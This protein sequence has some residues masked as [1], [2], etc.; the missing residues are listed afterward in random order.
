[1]AIKALV[2]VRLVRS[3]SFKR[4]ACDEQRVLSTKHNR[5]LV[6]Y[7]TLTAI[8]PGPMRRVI[9]STALWVSDATSWYFWGARCVTERHTAPIGSD[10][11][12]KRAA[13]HR[14]QR[15][16]LVDRDNSYCLRCRNFS[17][18]AFWARVSKKRPLLTVTHVL[19]NFGV[20]ANCPVAPPSC[21]GPGR[22]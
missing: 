10:L 2:R 12:I 11:A 14:Q 19:E 8:S 3:I 22:N 18:S 6:H 20:G 1:M 5:A 13:Q 15:V 4:A 17:S 7:V 21:C 9:A 16:N